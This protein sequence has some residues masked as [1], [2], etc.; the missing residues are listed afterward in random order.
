MNYTDQQEI[1][2]IEVVEPEILS[3]G[4]A[5]EVCDPEDLFDVIEQCK[6]CGRCV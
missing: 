4:S 6:I 3:C 1:N 5:T 2:N